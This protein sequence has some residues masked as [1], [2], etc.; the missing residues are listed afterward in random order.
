MW[1]AEH[2][3]AASFRYVSTEAQVNRALQ[4]RLD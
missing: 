2:R 4:A 1:F 3:S